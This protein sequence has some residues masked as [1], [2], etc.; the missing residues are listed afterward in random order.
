MSMTTSD[1]VGSM[2]VSAVIHVRRMGSSN[3]IRTDS[4]FFMA[5]ILR[6]QIE[7]TDSIISIRGC[8]YFRV[9]V[10][11]VLVCYREDG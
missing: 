7:I 6:N 11:M 4:D 8:C 2:S 1:G 9:S 3:P 5:E 10:F